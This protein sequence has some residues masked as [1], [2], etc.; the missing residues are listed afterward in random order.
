M[1]IS[2][3]V[4]RNLINISSE[5]AFCED[6]SCF[7]QAGVP[8]TPT[9]KNLFVQR[10]SP[11]E[12]SLLSHFPEVRGSYDKKQ[13]T[14]VIL[15]KKKNASEGWVLAVVMGACVVGVHV[16]AGVSWSARE[17]AGRRKEGFI[18]VS[19]LDHPLSSLGELT[20]LKHELL[21]CICS[22]LWLFR[23]NSSFECPIK[24]LVLN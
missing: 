12:Q 2:F 16:W 7:S 22:Y 17:R 5:R 1:Q 18:C 23:I 15:S 4:Q 20:A 13:Q 21:L 14:K 3:T 6:K 19:P 8:P 9:R 10:Q 11:R 24:E